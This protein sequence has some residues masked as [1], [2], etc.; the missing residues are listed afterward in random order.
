M[1]TRVARI[2]IKDFD[3]Y[4]DQLKQ[5]LDPTVTILQGVNNYIKKK[6]K[7]V[8]FA[9]GEDENMLKAAIA[10][11]SSKLGIPILIGKE[12][13]IKKQI[14][15]IGYNE[16]FDIEIVNSKDKEKRERYVKYLFKKLQREKGMLERD[17]DRLIRNDRVIWASCMVA[18]NDADAMVTGNTRR[19]S[20]SLEKVIQ[21]VD[22]RPGEIMFGLNLVVNRGKTIFTVSY[23]HLTL[24]TNREV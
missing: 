5:R 9:D 8:V 6:Q 15:K 22:P 13:L 3:I 11:K 1:E 21:V 23:T 16:D 18:C 10:F 4:K 17:C 12:E 2:D 7:K 19:Y 20:S 14:K 24:P